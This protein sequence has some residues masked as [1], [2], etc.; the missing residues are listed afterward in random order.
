M[1]ERVSVVI[2]TYDRAYCVANAID[3]A[4]AQ[5]HRDLEIIVV[6]DG[7]RDDTGELVRARYGDE[8]RVR[9]VR[10]SNAG[11]G[12]ARN[13]GIRLVRGDFVAL[14]DSDDRWKPWK[15]ELQLDVLRHFADAGL[16][17]TDLDEVRPSGE[18][19]RRRY[20]R[21]MF[22]AYRF[23]PTPEAL[24]DRAIPLVQVSACS[25]PELAGRQAYCGDVFSPMVLGNL[26]YTSSVMF[27]RERLAATGPFREDV[28]IAEDH[29]HYLRACRHGR[30]AFADVAS[31]LYQR[32]RA[33]QIT[34]REGTLGMARS[35]FASVMP[36][37]EAERERLKLP[38]EMIETMVMDAHEW[39]GVALLDDGQN[40]AAAKHLARSLAIDPARPRMLGY[41]GLALV[42]A[43]VTR[44]LRRAYGRA[45]AYALRART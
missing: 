32:G 3:S 22:Q 33:D 42:P 38:P 29:D 27:R 34:C 16:V 19:G 40:L 13:H 8:P 6:D 36:V 25:A 14:L 2:P 4:L 24:F 41:L 23:F 44:V 9:Y 10:Q 20:L 17:W 37:L 11:V 31:T 43:P 28:K 18:L 5:T 30:V 35:F 21:S 12:A 39:I 15:L 1:N 7:S 45:K 26:I